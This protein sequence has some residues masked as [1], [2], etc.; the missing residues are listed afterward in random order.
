[1]HE[2][3]IRWFDKEL[4]ARARRFA[5]TNAV[6]VSAVIAAALERFLLE[7]PALVTIQAALRVAEKLRTESILAANPDLVYILRGDPQVAK[8][9]ALADEQPAEYHPRLKDWTPL[10]DGPASPIAADELA[11]G[12]LA[13]GDDDE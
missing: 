10:W 12:M 1:M 8:L 3:E 13:G 5:L 6:S 2:V 7:E 9:A 11:A 4:M